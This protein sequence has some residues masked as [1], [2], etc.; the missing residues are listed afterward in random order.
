MSGVST[1]TD[2]NFP[3]RPNVQPVHLED[4]PISAQHV[5]QGAVLIAHGSNVVANASGASAAW[6]TIGYR[7]L[8]V[9][10]NLTALTGT[11]PTCQFV[12]LNPASESAIN[13]G[14]W[15]W[16]SAS[17]SAPNAVQGIIGAAVSG[18]NGFVL[19]QLQLAWELAG[20][21]PQATFSWEVW[22]WAE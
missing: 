15:F 20:T 13:V 18:D 3:A 14:W 7:R 2:S 19:P 22:G 17:L 10:V 9:G 12:L 1:S 8:F 5:P 6:S 4:Q 16:S 21:T 11:T